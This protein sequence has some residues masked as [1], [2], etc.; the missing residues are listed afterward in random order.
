MLYTALTRHRNKVVIFYQGEFRDIQRYSSADY[1]EIA[2]RLTNL[3][4]N[5]KPISTEVQN[6]HIFM[7]DFL[8]HRT[9]RGHLVRSKSE[10]IIA[11]KLHAAGLDYDYEPQIVLNGSERYPD[12][13]ITD[14]D[15]GETY[16]WE[17]L[18][19]MSNLKYRRRWEK[20]L[21]EYR[22][23]GILPLEEGGGKN[24]ILITTE[25]YQGEGFDSQKIDEL[26]QVVLE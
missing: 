10:L 23:E 20:K 2:R 5:P 9:Q 13:V 25:E 19:M 12:F 15:S 11:D 1:S 18:G 8:I 6:Q 4:R 17:H 22:A 7:D 24:G 21:V 26:V 14:D 3:F 16:Y